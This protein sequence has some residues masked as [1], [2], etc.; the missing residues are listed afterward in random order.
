MPDSPFRGGYGASDEA[1][2]KRTGHEWAHWYRVLDTWGGAEK[3]HAEIA[4]FLNLDLGVDGWWAQE[5]TVRYEMAIGR[6]LPGQR[7][8]GFEATAAE[9]LGA[10]AE[11]VYEAFVDDAASSGLARPG[12]PAANGHR[13]RPHGAVRLGRRRPTGR[14]SG[15]PRR[16]TEPRSRWPTSGCPM[17]TTAAAMRAFWRER[18]AA[19]E[20][21]LDEG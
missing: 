15:S 5:L 17:P 3:P 9:T 10:P 19:L 2:V 12:A 1:L 11:R 21:Q 14:R 6:R 13:P 20:R 16:A 18:I 4:R 7:P 8:D